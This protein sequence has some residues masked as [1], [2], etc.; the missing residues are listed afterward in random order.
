MGLL[1]NTRAAF[2]VYSSWPAIY[3]F[4]P[5]IGSINQK[6]LKVFFF[7]KSTVS[8]ETTGI[9]GVKSFILSVSILLTSRSP[10]V[11]GVLSG[12]IIFFNP[13]L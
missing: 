2:T 5:S 10:F 4:V 11:T 8:S 12:L 3:S 6:V 13:L 1:S 7:F 9:F